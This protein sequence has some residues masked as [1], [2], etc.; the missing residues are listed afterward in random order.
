MWLDNIEIEW[1]KGE[2]V[3]EFTR[4]ISFLNGSIER[5]F[6]LTGAV[7]SLGTKIFGDFGKGIGLDK[8]GLNEAKKCRCNISICD[9]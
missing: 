4:N 8:N 7:T 3:Q 5:L 9:E 6:A 2:N 1:I